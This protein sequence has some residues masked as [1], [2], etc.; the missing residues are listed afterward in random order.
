VPHRLERCP[1]CV[2]VH[3]DLQRAL[4]E[5]GHWDEMVAVLEL[6]AAPELWRSLAALPPDEKRR[7]ARKREELHTW[8]LTRL[9]LRMSAEPREEPAQAAQLARLAIASP[10]RPRARLL[11]PARAGP[12]LGHLGGGLTAAGRRFRL[13]GQES[14]RKCSRSKVPAKRGDDPDQVLSRLDGRRSN[15]GGVFYE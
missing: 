6:D 15:L 1:E 2:Q 5:V 7:A 11:P 9:L 8:G 10:S 4:R 12:A 3:R 14:S 13:R